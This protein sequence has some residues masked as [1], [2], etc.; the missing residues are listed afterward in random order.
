MNS[1]HKYVDEMMETM[2]DHFEEDGLEL[3]IPGKV[4]EEL[5]QE[6]IVRLCDEANAIHEDLELA[7]RA[8]ARMPKDSTKGEVA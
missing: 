8:H 6:M 4:F 2:I 3:R 5:R 1:L 7:Y